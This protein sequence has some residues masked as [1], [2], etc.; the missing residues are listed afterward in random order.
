MGANNCWRGSFLRLLRGR[1][2]TAEIV[3]SIMFLVILFF[4]FTNVYLWHDEATREMNDH[5]LD[6]VNSSVSIEAVDPTSNPLVLKVTNNG[7]VGFHL[8]RLWIIGPDPPDYVDLE[9]DNIWVAGGETWEID[10]DAPSVE[11]TFKILTDL[12]NSASW[13]FIPP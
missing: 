13:K 9:D 6:R 4:F 11:V 3:G 8:S 2:G 7:G 5:V 12:G 1:R 10:Y